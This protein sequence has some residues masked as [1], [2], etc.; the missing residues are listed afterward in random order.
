MKAVKQKLPEDRVADFEKGAG[1]YAKKIVANFKDYE[2]VCFS[3][4]L[5]SSCILTWTAVHRRVHG[6]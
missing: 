2:F 4:P 3:H 5:V 1:A 6:S